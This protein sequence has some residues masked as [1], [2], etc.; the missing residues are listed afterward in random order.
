MKSEDSSNLKEQNI[1]HRTVS[2][3]NKVLIIKNN[4]PIWLNN[5][6]KS[7]DHTA[8]KQKKTHEG[9]TYIHVNC[10]HPPSIL[11]QPPISIAKGLSSLS[12]P[13]EVFE[14]TTPYYG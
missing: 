5:S 1:Y 2:F 10:D 6:E 13:E 9:A 8:L 3:I 7:D 4:R 14:E 11:K 12:S